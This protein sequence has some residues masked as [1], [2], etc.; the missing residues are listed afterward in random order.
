[1]GYISIQNAKISEN[2][3]ARWFII[4]IRIG[5]RKKTKKSLIFSLKWRKTGKNVSPKGR[6]AYKKNV[7]F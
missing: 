4:R 3:Y 5:K 1:M 2:I 6:Q 7:F